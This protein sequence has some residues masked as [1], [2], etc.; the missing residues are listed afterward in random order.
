MAKQPPAPDALAKEQ[1]RAKLLDEAFAAAARDKSA[2]PS[3][4]QGGDVG[5]FYRVSNMVEPFARAAFALKP[6][7]MSDLVRTQFGFHLILVLERQ[8]GK[9]VKFDELKE[10]VKAV[11]AE[12]LRESLVAQLRPRASIVL[13][14]PPAAPNPAPAP[15]Q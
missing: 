9:D 4:E 6:Y 8:P 7:Q 14:P 2:C 13:S 3:K 12:R 15:K 1:A 11:Y 5:S 10:D